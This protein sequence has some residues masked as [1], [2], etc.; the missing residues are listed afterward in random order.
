MNNPRCHALVLA[1]G[2]GRRFGA[3]KPKQFLPLGGLSVL[4][5]CL[6]NLQSWERFTS[7]TVVLPKDYQGVCLPEGIGRSL[8]GETRAQSSALGLKSL[9]AEPDD[10]VFIHDAARAL[11]SKSMLDRLYEAAKT[12]GA[13]LPVLPVSDTIKVL[14]KDGLQTLERDTLRR[15]QTPQVFRYQDICAAHEYAHEQ[16]IRDISDDA[17]LIEAMG[18]DIVLVEG[19][20]RALKITHPSDLQRAEQMLA[21]PMQTRCGFGYDVHRFGANSSYDKGI[22]RLC[23]V[24]IPFEEALEGHSDADVGLHALCDAIFGALAEGDIGAHFPPNDPKWHRA[25]SDQFLAFAVKRVS[26]RRGDIINIDVTLVCEQPKISLYR[27]AMRA[28]IARIAGLDTGRVSVKGTTSERLGFTGRMEGIAA[29]AVA[30]LS[31]PL[32]S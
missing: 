12:K 18:V 11:V 19:D 5:L 23:G 14:T 28:K 29:H 24:D 22:I 32:E 16:G 8:G 27:D 7:I 1:A 20:E 2:C 17:S 6:D 4:E 25:S 15:A 9:K 30:T 3:S 21:L 10:L 13:A 31:L 26:E